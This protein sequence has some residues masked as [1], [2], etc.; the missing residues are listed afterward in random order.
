M[1]LEDEVEM[2]GC[3]RE[4]SKIQQHNRGKRTNPGKIEGGGRSSQTLSQTV[5]EE[6]EH[7]SAKE[8]EGGQ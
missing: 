2:G 4:K 1:R 6:H 5:K 8:N 7:E 3:G